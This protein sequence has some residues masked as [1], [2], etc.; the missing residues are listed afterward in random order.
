M[1]PRPVTGWDEQDA[2]TGWRKVL[3][4]QRGELAKTK[5]R[6]HH[7]ERRWGKREIEEHLH[8]QED[9][10]GHRCRG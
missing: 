7:K 5:R 9:I 1:T 2:F 10:P 6:Y 4:W 3:F 8:D